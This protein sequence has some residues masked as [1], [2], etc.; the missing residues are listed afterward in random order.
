MAEAQNKQCVEVC[1]SKLVEYP[2]KYYKAKLDWVQRNIVVTVVATNLS[3]QDYR[4]NIRIVNKES[5]IL[6]KVI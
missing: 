5:V 1:I 4:V 2:P 6:D 3:L